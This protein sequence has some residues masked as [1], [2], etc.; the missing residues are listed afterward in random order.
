MTE[1]P[2]GDVAARRPAR[3]QAATITAI[4]RL[5][6]R[7]MSFRLRPSQPFAYAAGQHVDVRLTA[8][9]GYTA[10]RSY[11]IAS[12]PE[13]GDEIEL[14]IE[15][16]D[17]GEVSPFF[18]EVAAVGDAIE[19][20]APLGGHFVWNAAEAG[21]IA[22]I[23]GGSGVVPLASMIRHRAA[24]GANVPASLIYSSRELDEVI[25]RDEFLA[26][27]D[28]RD[29]FDLTLTL[30]RDQPRRDKD[31][32]RRIDAEMIA[33]V[34]SRLPQPPALA[35]VCGANAFVTAAADALI[36]AGI[37]A[38]RIRTERYGV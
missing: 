29:G 18:H 11:S 24:S 17:D 21:P 16:L 22:M 26:L 37:A 8:P 5:T 15:R 32:S 38:E 35:Y 7:V 27:D 19:V 28:K 9:D 14:A 20:K 30:T 10:Q 13:A 1:T 31:F 2:A 36:A 23:G 34:L 12:A 6:P 33:A 3:W 4:E 25:F